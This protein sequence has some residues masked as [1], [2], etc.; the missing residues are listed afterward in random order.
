V[1]TEVDLQ[2]KETCYFADKQGVVYSMA[3]VFSGNAYPKIFTGG[4]IESLPFTGISFE[5]LSMINKITE[6]LS[7][8]GI[9]PTKFNFVSNRELKI[10]FIHN[11]F[12][13]EIYIDPNNSIETSLE[14]LFSGLRTTPLSTSFR[15]IQKKLLY[16]DLRFPNKIVYKFE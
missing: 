10:G 7:G 4:P 2:I 12:N 3:P 11:S 8:I 14:Y 15:D 1:N 16:I 13:S 9:Y 6:R 5:S